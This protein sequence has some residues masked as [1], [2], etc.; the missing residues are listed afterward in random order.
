[1]ELIDRLLADDLAGR[2]GRLTRH[3]VL[4]G[5]RPDGSEVRLPPYGVNL[6]IAG[7]SGGGKTTLTAAL[8]ER[9]SGAGYQCCVIDPEGDYEGLEGTALLGTREHRPSADEV[10]GLLEKP[11]V[12]LVV[13]LL[14]V[15]LADRPP[16]FLGLLTRLR[17]LRTRTGRPHWLIVD[18]T[19]HVLPQS[20]EPSQDGLPRWVHNMV[21]ITVHPQTVS[22]PALE[23]VDVVIGVGEDAA[24]TLREFAAAVGGA[25]PP[26]PEGTPG[27]GEALVWERHGG[28]PPFLMTVTPGQTERRRHQRKYAVGELPPVRSF[29]FRGPKGKLNL[30]A[31]NLILFLQMA[32]GVADATWRFHLE[33]GD[34]SRWFR[35]SI[36]D[37]DLAAEAALVEAEKGLP[38]SE[39]RARIRRAV[40]SR[41]TLPAS[42]PLPLPGT[43]AAP[44][45]S[46]EKS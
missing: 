41:Y 29:Y 40:E 17:E 45:H 5:T 8:V 18:E 14:G 44:R 20:W 25:E 23:P 36:K 12:N 31:Q 2:E 9:L 46:G 37:E 43:D 26:L 19:H 32:D 10:L 13:S 22:R 3:H 42:P 27:P 11:A 4:L 38:A 34:V 16:F 1:V 15:P 30:R 39:S 7:A 33:A 24:A 28:A 35:E 21:R 6:L